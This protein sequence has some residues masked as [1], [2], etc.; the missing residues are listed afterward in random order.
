MRDEPSD[1]ALAQAAGTGDAAAFAALLER[2]YDR[3]YRLAWRVLGSRAEAEDVTQDVCMTLGAKLA[4]FRGGAKFTTW[5][6]RVVVNA[7]RDLMR[8]RATRDKAAAGWGEAETAARADAATAADAAHWLHEAMAALSPSLR[9][10]VAL[11]LGE[12]CSQAEAAQVLGV[13]EGTIAWR[14]SEAKKALAAQAR[15]QEVTL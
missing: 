5:L 10:T 12:D 13:S 11:I 4:G 14:M 7:A 3:I 1:E 2:H 15:A 8:R 9:E 6:H